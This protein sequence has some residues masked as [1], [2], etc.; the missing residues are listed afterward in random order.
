MPLRSQPEPP[1]RVGYLT[2]TQAPPPPAFCFP[3]RILT[4]HSPMP[5]FPACFT[6]WPVL[7]AHPRCDKHQTPAFLRLSNTPLYK[8]QKTFCYIK[9]YDLK[10][11]RD[12]GAAPCEASFHPLPPSGC[13]P[14]M[15]SERICC[16][17]HPGRA[18]TASEPRVF[19][20]ELS[21]NS[22]FIYC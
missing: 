15:G 3:L 6:R 9:K 21:G 18:T 14:L 8:V 20:T 10:K 19:P 16:I 5:S 1:S 2:A 17:L 12:L 7:R 22:S 13:S 4:E 11:N